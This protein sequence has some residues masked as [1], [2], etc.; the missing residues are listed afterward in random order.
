MSDFRINDY[1]D[2]GAYQILRGINKADSKYEDNTDTSIM[3]LADK[4]AWTSKLHRWCYIPRIV[5]GIH[6]AQENIPI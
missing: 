6:D 2:A 1:S 4:K 3:D 5:R